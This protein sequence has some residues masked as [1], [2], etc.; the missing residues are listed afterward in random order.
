MDAA[1]AWISLAAFTI[2]GK[3]GIAFK[4]GGIPAAEI[5]RMGAWKK[6]P[7]LGPQAYSTLLPAEIPRI[8][9]IRN[10]T[11]KRKNRNFA[12][13]AAAAA[14]PVNPSSAAT[15]A[16]TKKTTAQY[17]ISIYLLGIDSNLAAK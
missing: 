13:P 12:I 16:M 8:K 1:S 11:R 2:A 9:K 4:S 5:P 3:T 14:I 15:N 7:I 17:N 10:I 6:R